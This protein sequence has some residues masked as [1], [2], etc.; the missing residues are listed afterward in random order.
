MT[1]T[2]KAPAGA[3]HD[4]VTPDRIFEIAQGFM[5]S[6]HLFAASEL[7]IFEA[8]GEG[9]VDLDG[10]AA[11]TGLARRTARISV[12]AMVAIGLVERHGDRYAN[13]SVS[14]TFLSGATP[15]DLRPLLRFWDRLSYPVWEDLAGALGR[16]RPAREIFEIDDAMVPIMS[17]GI[18]A[19]TAAACHA[20]PVVA[21]LPGASRVLDI[22]G[23]N[24]SWS[25]ALAAADPALTATV[26]EIADVARVAQEQLRA[27]P[28]AD[29]I[30]VRVG[31][32]QTDDLPGGYDAFLVANLVHYFTPETNQ[33][34]LHRIRAGAGPG[35]RLLLADFWTDP[36]HTEP[37]PA[38]LMAGEFA[39]HV[40][41]GDVYSVE[42]C[43]AWLTAT[44][45]RLTG[46][47]PLAGPIS[48]VTAEAV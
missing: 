34:I 9:P 3:A 21:G 37:L 4:V 28:Y 25:I 43:S 20:L 32:V 36:T 8:L 45:W 1:T 14:A 41:D 38:A 18:A 6:K 11:R 30:D 33:A 47:A 26:L 29:R 46:H 17:A 44:G 12:D 40:K 48:L 24:G 23:G 39:I 27:T 42:E 16:G 10:L 22:G 31:D 35:A 19:A 5:A 15:A 2:Q 7:G 13:S